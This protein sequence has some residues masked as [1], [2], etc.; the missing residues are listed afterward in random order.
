MA[1]ASSTER[2]DFIVDEFGFHASEE[3]R[4]DNLNQLED[5]TWDLGQLVAVVWQDLEELL[6]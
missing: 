2:L 1:S 3:T 5:R 6:I 4:F